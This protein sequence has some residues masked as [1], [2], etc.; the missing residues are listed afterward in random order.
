VNPLEWSTQKKVIGLTVLIW[1]GAS[2]TYFFSLWWLALSVIA[3]LVWFP[4]WLRWD[5]EIRK[6]IREEK[7][8]REDERELEN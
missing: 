6:E 8:R 4:L 3:F 5:K 2:L 1:V 7:E